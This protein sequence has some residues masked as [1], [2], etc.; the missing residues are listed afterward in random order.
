MRP[1]CAWTTSGSG[2]GTRQVRC[3]GERA[4]RGREGKRGKGRGKVEEK[5]DKGEGEGLQGIQQVRCGGGR[6]GWAEVRRRGAQS[7][8]RDALQVMRGLTGGTAE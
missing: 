6:A 5:I 4:G 7:R 2:W 1:S 8:R 3:G